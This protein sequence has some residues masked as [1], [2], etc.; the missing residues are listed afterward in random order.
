[1]KPE[2]LAGP[3]SSAEGRVSPKQKVGGWGVSGLSM[4]FGPLPW[5][6]KGV[7]LG[8]GPQGGGAGDLTFLLEQDRGRGLGGKAG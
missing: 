2:S 6:R 1:M 4:V 7:S 3:G 8:L 5:A